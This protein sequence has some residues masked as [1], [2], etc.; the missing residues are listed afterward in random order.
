ML[1][2]KYGERLTLSVV[3]R[4]LHKRDESKDVLEKVTLIKDIDITTPHRAHIEILF[5]IHF[6][7]LQRKHAV[8]NFVELHNAWQKTLDSS[9]LNKKF[10]QELANWYFWAMP[11]VEF[12]EDAEENRDI[13]NAT[14]LI[15]LLTRVIFVWFIK[16]KGLIPKEL[17]DTRT[18]E[19]LLNYQDT[20]DSTFYKA[21]LQNLFF[22][23]LNQEQDKRAFRRSGQNYNITNL[24]RYEHLFRVSQEN[25][26][27]HFKEI[28]FLNG[29]L[30]ECLDKPHP[31]EK[32]TRGAEKIVRIDGFSDRDDNPLKVP[33]TLFF[34]DEQDVDLNEVYGTKNKRYKVKGLIPLLGRYKFT[35][36]ENTPI[37][38]EIALDPELLGKVF[39]NLLAAYNP[40]TRTTARKQ[41][42]SF[43]TP[44]EIVD[45]MVD[46][47][48]KASLSQRV[49]NT[50]PDATEEDM[51]T[52]FDILFAYTE[53]EH[54]FTD[55]EVSKIIEAIAELKILDPACGS[56]AFPMGILHK[57]VFILSKLDSENRVWRELQKQKALQD[58]EDAYNAESKE[59]RRQ[60]LQEIEEAFDLN[61]SDYGRKLYLIENSIYGVDIQPVAVQ[62][63]MLRFFISLIVDQNID[64]TRE[65]FGIRPLPNLETKFVAA[66][67]LIGTEKP[68][69][70]L[71]LFDKSE[72]ARLEKS[73]QEIRHKHFRARTPQTKRKYR[74]ADKDIRENITALLRT[75]FGDETAAKQLAQWN[76]YDQNAK[77]DFFDPEWMFGIQEGFDI[78]IGNPPYV[79]LQ[80]NSGQLAQ[81]YK[82][83]LFETFIRTGDIY[84]LFYEK[85]NQLLKEG[86]VTCYI[87]SNK[88]MRAAYGE[89]L[90]R[91]FARQIQPL[92]LIDVGPGVFEAATVDTNILLF[93]KNKATETFPGCKLEQKAECSLAEF[94]QQS[95]VKISIK[96]SGERW[97]IS[98]PFQQVLTLK[99]ER[100][101]TPLKDW[102]ISI[103]FGVKTG[104]NKA[105][106]I[107][108]VKK[109]E[110]V[111]ADPNSADLI[112][113]LLR[114]RDIQPYK[115]QFADS[116]LIATFPTLHFNIEHY[117]SVRDYLKTFGKRLEQTG[118]KGCR[119][120]TNHQ[121]FE[122]QDNIAFYQEFEKEKIVWKRIGS[123]M[124]FS[125]DDSGTYCLDSTCIA[126]GEKIKFLVGVLNSKM[127][128]HELFR[129]SPKTGTGDQIISVQALKPLCI[130]KPNRTQEQAITE[131]VDQILTAKQQNPAADTSKLERRIDLMVYR[132]YDLTYDEVKIVE[133]EFALSAEEY[134]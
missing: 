87:T 2:F 40:E 124:R 14:S 113:P 112:K 102:D 129:I 7:Q 115:A 54:A 22:A 37:T 25:A 109:D 118:E 98:S 24:Y 23:T 64:K 52:G 95:S 9:E 31:T 117:P 56:G 12:P 108:G 80:S 55:D 53:Q 42:G 76:P 82:D 36:A 3:K 92:K 39:E 86:G 105:F 75:S 68:Q 48:L 89:K 91:Y 8:T 96:P 69:K 81:K 11:R 111:A 35:I 100:C 27:E 77:A 49:A 47:S 41:T 18:L 84:C 45:Y 121:W 5:D 34:S 33:D 125:Y 4:R 65:N 43:Y 90:R 122:T 67:T 51:R 6:D 123:I 101:G 73:L 131:L 133:P 44:R 93:A 66:N 126:T 70:Q 57:L 63:S 60:R 128:L 97:E 15:R 134:Q 72:I 71:N 110:L 1:L 74:Q 114:G 59:E 99:I 21:I 83:Q 88:W 132:L 38:E 85:A 116:W 10:Y 94:V 130:P 28:P 119:K 20:H 107:D 103:Y 106:I 104:Y 79:Q 32:T 26:I 58:T 13:R 17:F 78:V 127:C 50:L 16:E 30:F 62:I 46:E 61:T 19:T 120:K 29:G